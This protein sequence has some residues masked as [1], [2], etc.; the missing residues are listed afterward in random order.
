MSIL[1]KL[2]IVEKS[3]E[4]DIMGNKGWTITA[5]KPLQE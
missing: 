2:G 5:L 3:I 4:K 1:E